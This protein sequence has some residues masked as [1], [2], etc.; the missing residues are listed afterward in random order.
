MAKKLAGIGNN[1]YG[2]THTGGPKRPT[3]VKGGPKT[4][5]SSPRDKEFDKATKGTPTQKSAPKFG[6]LNKEM[7]DINTGR[8]PKPKSGSLNIKMKDIDAGRKPKPK[9]TS[10]K[11]PSMIKK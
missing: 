9:S 2:V 10:T 3:A 6:S 1:S 5:S 7:K 4:V 8:K 11:S